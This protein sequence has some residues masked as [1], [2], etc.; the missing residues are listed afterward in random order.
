MNARERLF[1]ALE[2]K[3]PDRVPTYE[4]YVNPK[5]VTALVGAGDYLD[6]AETL[7][8]DG[9]APNFTSPDYASG[10]TWIDRQRRIFRDRWGALRQINEEGPF[11][12]E[13][14]IRTA[15]DLR[16]YNPPDPRHSGVTEL[17][18]E[19]AARFRG[20]K[21]VIYMGRDSWIVPTFL[22][23]MEGL[24]MDFIDD[25]RFARDLMGMTVEYSIEANRQAISAGAEVIVLGDDYAFK[26]SSLMSPKH[27]REFILPGLT[28]VVRDIKR[29]GVYCVKHSDG[30]I[31]GLLDM[32]VETGVDAVGPLEPGA[33]MDLA[34]VKAKY[35]HRVCVVGNIDIDLLSRGAI[36]EVEA[37]V[38]E[39][40]NKNAPGGGYVLSSANTITASVNPANYRTMV[41]ACRKY[42]RYPLV[43]E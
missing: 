31:W 6:L 34:A 43:M 28:R 35:G 15:E 41:E 17:V 4:C 12:I 32:I 27:F 24:L 20:R 39:A 25:P 38:H 23:G 21:A 33:G 14:P 36:A 18:N 7:D 30:N 9:V 26:T 1:A 40:I 11:V 13:H 19:I 37:A 22:R 8:V 10:M 16:A 3:V 42:G 2:R 5:V 29:Q